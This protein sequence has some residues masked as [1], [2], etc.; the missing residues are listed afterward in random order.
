MI[1]VFEEPI[2][3]DAFVISLLR[4]SLVWSIY[5]LGF[6]LAVAVPQLTSRRVRTL[7]SGLEGKGVWRRAPL[8]R[9]IFLAS[10]SWLGSGSV[11]EAGFWEEFACPTTPLNWKS[12]KTSSPL[13][14]MS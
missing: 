6:V 7:P 2:N 9:A 4:S 14:G 10:S 1:G 11:L 8:K 3:Y 12:F 5:I 13:R